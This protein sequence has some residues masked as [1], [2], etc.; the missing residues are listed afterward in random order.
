[1]GN[2]ALL[3]NNL[4]KNSSEVHINDNQNNTNKTGVGAF[5]RKKTKFPKLANLKNDFDDEE[6]DK[7]KEPNK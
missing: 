4:I 6:D 5:K 7:K 1:M 3:C 2:C